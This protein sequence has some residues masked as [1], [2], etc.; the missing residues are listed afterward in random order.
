MVRT[1]ADWTYNCRHYVLHQIWYITRGR[2]SVVPS[3]LVEEKKMTQLEHF[4]VGTTL[5]MIL[6]LFWLRYY[7]YEEKDYKR[8]ERIIKRWWY[9]W[10]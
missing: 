8:A 3:F 7:F 2:H 5:F 4:I 9:F 10:R 6:W 1:S